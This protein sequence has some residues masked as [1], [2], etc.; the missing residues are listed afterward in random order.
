MH[1]FDSK[2]NHQYV[3]VDNDSVECIHKFRGAN[4]N[5]VVEVLEAIPEDNNEEIKIPRIEES[6]VIKL[7]LTFNAKALCNPIKDVKMLSLSQ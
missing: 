5:L 4:I 1:N 3:A 7:H 6:I 2:S